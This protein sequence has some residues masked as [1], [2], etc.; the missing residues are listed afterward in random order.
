M[1]LQTG[2]EGGYGNPPYRKTAW[3]VMFVAA[4]L[5]I[6]VL[7]VPWVYAAPVERRIHIEAGMFEFTPSEITV[8]PGDR[9][10]VEL[11]STDVVHG[12]SL[13]G[14]DFELQANPGQTAAAVFVANKPGMFRFRCSVAC[15]NMHPFMIGKL[16]VGPNLFLLRGAALGLLGAAA[17]LVLWQRRGGYEAG[18][19]TRPTLVERREEQ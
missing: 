19:E 7:P 14:Y 8:N 9:V 1:R 5:L 11:V 2:E 17:G 16:R 3:V 18:I 12:L 13:D 4:A 6:L 15:G 10:T